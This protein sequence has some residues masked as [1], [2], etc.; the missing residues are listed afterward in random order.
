V[1]HWERL[2]SGKYRGCWRDVS[3]RKCYTRRPEFPHHPYLRKSDALAAAQEAEVRAR[4]VAAVDQGTQ[5]ASITWGD[6]WDQSRPQRDDTDT[7]V[8]VAFL[9]RKYL[10]P[11]WGETPLNKITRKA[12]QRWV[13][14]ELVPGKSRGYVRK[15]FGVFRASLNRAVEEEVLEASPCVK[16]TVPSPRKR[17]MPYV[18]ET[19]LEMLTQPSADQLWALPDPGHRAMV[20]VA[21]ETGLRPGELCG[22]HAR[23]VD[24][25]T[26]W[27]EVSHVR[28][29]Y[30]IRAWPKDEDARLVPLTQTAAEILRR[31]IAERKGQGCGVPHADGSVCRD[32][33]VFRTRRGVPIAPA[34]WNA[35]MRRASIKLGVKN[36]SPYALRRGAATWMAE[37]GVDAFTIAAI[38]GHEDVALTTGYVQRTSAARDKLRAARG[39]MAGLSVIEGGAPIQNISSQDLTVRR[40]GV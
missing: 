11:K 13:T 19:R 8:Q 40:T 21:F 7:V 14:D 18:D 30:V 33:L 2:P 27:V 9:V 35:A 20:A 1:A 3:G 29:R 28:T 6:W 32:D 16:I 17:P 15:I 37:A 38:F 26:G 23:Q 22:M 4:R 10:R 34:G 31:L 25:D 39:E 36:R 24:L 12:V 5:A